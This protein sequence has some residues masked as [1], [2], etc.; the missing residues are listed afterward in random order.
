M[1]GRISPRRNVTLT[2]RGSG[3]TGPVLETHVFGSSGRVG[4]SLRWSRGGGGASVTP[5]TR[6]TTES[7]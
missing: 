1:G 7:A 6:I 2:R 3:T 4:V 5:P